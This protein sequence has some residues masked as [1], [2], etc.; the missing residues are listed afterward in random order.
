MTKL[1]QRVA[2]MFFRAFVIGSLIMMWD[3][4]AI[5][6]LPLGVLVGICSEAESFTE[7]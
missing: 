6:G 2:R 5:W 3:P 4:K 7:K 1:I